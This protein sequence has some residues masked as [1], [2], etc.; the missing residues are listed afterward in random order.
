MKSNVKSHV[1]YTSLL[2]L[3]MLICGGQSDAMAQNGVGKSAQSGLPG[4]RAV[5]AKGIVTDNTQEPLLGATVRV[6]GTKIAT[7]TDINGKFSLTMPA[8]E[9]GKAYFLEISYLG[10]EKKVVRFRD[11]N[12]MRIAMVADKS[13]QL[14]EVEVVETGYGRLPRKDM[15]GAFT[16]VKADDIMMPAYQTIDQMLQGKIAGLMVVNSSTRVG[17]APKLTIRGKSTILGNTD[18]LWVVDGVIQEAPLS[19]DASAAMTTDMKELIGN[20]VSWLNPQDIETITVLKDASATAIYGSKAS[21]GVIVITTK[22]GSAERTS[23]RYSTNISIRQRPNY[24]M[25]DYMNSKERIQFSK[26]A[27]DAGVRYQ[28]DPLP[29]IYTYEGLMAM[30]NKHMISETDFMK[31]MERLETVNTDWFDLLCRNSLSQN[32]NLSI[33]GGTQKVTYN[34]SFGYSNSKGTEIGNNQNQFTSR[35]NIG[36]QFN[37]RIRASFNISGSNRNSYGYSGVSPQS[38]A[39]STSRAV[40]A[41]EENG[42]R[43]FYK[44]YY[45]YQLNK[46]LG[47][48]NTY[49]YNVFN[50]MDNSYSKNRGNTFNVSANLDFQVLKWLN[51]QIVGSMQHSDNSSEGY[52]GERTAYIECNYRGYAVGAAE[53]GDALYKAAL[54]PYG[55]Q[56]TNNNTTM[57]S[58]DM[59]HRLVAGHTF[60]DIHRLNGMLGFEMRSAKTYGK[61]TNVWGYVPERGESLI[62]PS[63]PEDIVP[64]GG[65]QSIGWG[66]FKNLFEGGWNSVNNTSNYVSLFATAAYSLMNRYVVNMNIRSDASNRFGQDKRKQFDPTYSFGFSWKIA[67]EN[68]FKE[69]VKWVDQLNLRATYGIQGNVVNSISPELIASY[70]G[71]LSGYN[72]Y[73]ATIA[74]LPNPYLKW[75]R[76]KTWN[77]GL[78]IQLFRSVSM[79][80][81]YYGRRSNAIIEQDV[82][83]E[84]G[85]GTLRLNG[86]IIVNHGV[87]WSMNITPVKTKDWTVN[88]GFNASKNWNKT[89]TDDRT[90]RADQLTHKDFISGNSS[91]PLRKG[92]SLYSFWAYDFTG[93]EHE[94]GLPTFR[95]TSLE[96]P[97]D[98]G[99]KSID[100]TT[101]LV[102]AGESEPYFTGGFNPRVRWKDLQLSASFALILG[103]TKRLPNPYSSFSNGKMPSPLS[104]ISKQLLDRWKQPGDEAHT[105]IPG[106]Y[107]SVLDELNLYT[108]DGLFTNRYDMWAQSTARLVSGSFL[109][110]TQLSLSYNLPKSVCRLIRATGISLSANTNNIFVI[111]SKKWNGYDPETGSS[112]QPKIYSFGLSVSF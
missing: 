29:Q 59:Q 9:P 70:G 97:E 26:E 1:F 79:N 14:D 8:M 111:A 95:G 77:L 42:E 45:T 52:K 58:L 53:P 47:P 76:T 19:I 72:E 61:G 106:L 50:E 4:R 60:N 107:T 68:F 22:K 41:F 88:L 112:K 40:P 34:A 51:Y 55:G 109:R 63:K 66:A 11:S 101:F 24:G 21:N 13:S 62:A 81:E 49:G 33:S 35:L 84:Y 2:C 98:G 78:D 39:L 108:P 92:Y 89:E 71:V 82:A 43:A 102:Y 80:F 12:T 87:E 74:S 37:K 99:D 25:Y 73:Y 65:E 17:A 75:E 44:S 32:H 103:S 31:Q 48:N 85:M 15:V 69:H 93:L 57:N 104:N 54:L 16:T 83:E 6:R 28:S 90:A 38:Y 56:L 110:C 91:R 46:T 64:I 10:M 5:V 20:Q 3:P 67:E 96:A 18:P 36:I 105:N 30:F 86:G 27:Y 94:T 100:P 7:T 23:I